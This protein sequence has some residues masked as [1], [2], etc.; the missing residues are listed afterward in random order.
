[1]DFEIK[2]QGGEPISTVKV[3]ETEGKLESLATSMTPNKNSSN[4]SCGGGISSS[5]SGS[6]RGGNAKGWQY[7]Y[8][9]FFKVIS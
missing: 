8:G 6:S 5:S 1:M 9:P 3:S 4:S 7:R 2:M